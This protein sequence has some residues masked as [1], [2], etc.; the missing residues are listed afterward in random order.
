MATQPTAFSETPLGLGVRGLC[1]RCHRG[2]IFA[3]YL[4][5]AARCDAC[6]LDLGFA[7]P[8]DG[9]AFFAMSIV[10]LPAVGIA[11]WME[12]GLGVPIWL[13]LLATCLLAMASCCALLRPL[14]GWLVCS[15]YINKA[16]QARLAD[17]GDTDGPA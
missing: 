7:D 8:A 6:G 17:P 14:K 4:R 16:E 12:I 3:G 1:P 5:L 10:S 15:Q 13:N 9:P 2:R 11:A